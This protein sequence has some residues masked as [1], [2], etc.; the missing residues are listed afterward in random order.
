M[1]KKIL[2]LLLFLLVGCLFT[3]C[4]EVNKDAKRFKEDYEKLNGEKNSKGKEYRKITVDENN[5]YT[6]T[7]IEELNKMIDNK[8]SYIVYFG[9]NW[10]PWCRSMLETS[11]K[12]ANEHGIKKIY[13]IDVR[14]DNVIDNDLRDIYSLDEEGKVYLSHEGTDAYH[15]FTAATKD[16]LKDYNAGG[17]DVKGTEFEGAKRIGAPSFILIKDGKAVTRI[18]GISS[19]LTDAFAELTPEMIT[20]MEKIFDDFFKL[21]K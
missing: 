6:Y 15:K 14:P 3:G 2:V 17:V 18:S 16:V 4:E 5:P 19:L 10:C 8:E 11:I 1:K 7:T 21:Y 12:K 13:Y 20:D 9:A